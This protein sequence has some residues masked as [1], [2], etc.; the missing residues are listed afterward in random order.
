ML[1]HAKLACPL[2]EQFLLD[3]AVEHMGAFGRPDRIASIG[4]EQVD[5][6]LKG[7]TFN[8]YSVYRR[9]DAAIEFGI[10]FGALLEDA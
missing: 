8:R 7:S 10:E 2:D 1:V 9:G 6:L 3:Q 5:R 4:C